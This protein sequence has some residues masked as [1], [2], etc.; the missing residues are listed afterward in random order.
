MEA[1]DLVEDSELERRVDVAFLHVAAH[2][3]VVVDLEAVSELVNQPRVT[4]E[5]EDHGLVLREHA[6]EIALA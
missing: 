5:V 6:V 2:V 1:V 3:H 4:V